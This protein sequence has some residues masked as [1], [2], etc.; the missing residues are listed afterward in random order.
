M[1]DHR[2]MQILSIVG[3]VCAV[4]FVIAAVF[5]FTSPSNQARSR[6]VAATVNGSPIYEETVT[7]A[8]ELQR[9]KMGMSDSE[10]WKQFL[11]AGELT[12]ADV[13]AQEIDSYVDQELLRQGAGQL[14]VS[15]DESQVDEY[16]S[17]MK[18]QFDS[19][20]AWK[21]TLEGSGFTEESYRQAVSDMFLQQ[22]VYA[23]FQETAEP[24]QEE[25]AE[26]VKY[27]AAVFDG[28]KRS[29]HI[30]IRV[31][32]TAGE[33]AKEAA[34]T[35]AESVLQQVKSGQMSFE[36]AVTQYS[37]DTGSAAQGGDVGWDRSS[38]LAEP[39][40]QALDGLAVGEMSDV[41]ESEYGFHII[42]CTEEYK[43]PEGATSVDQLP[44][45][46]RETI[47]GMLR[48]QAA[49]SAYSDW[50]Q[51]LR[52]SAD[53]KINDMPSNVPYYVDPSELVQSAGSAASDGAESA[54]SSSE[55]SAS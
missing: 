45:S 17:S 27:Y 11:Q 32:S 47:M 9:E 34:R 6:T 23:H 18:A 25:T 49:G 14:G 53:I 5:A 50:I 52:E 40:Q 33:E 44:E 30:L 42:K 36:D 51:K 55:S 19:E 26:A 38:Q 10:T 54:A 7:S 22:S 28:S 12:P 15:V 8:I 3:A 2:K 13:R 1:S 20:D 48:E 39:Y 21:Q 24:S 31:D 16:I 4:A 35:E 29:S 43:A 46:L 41:V 37:A